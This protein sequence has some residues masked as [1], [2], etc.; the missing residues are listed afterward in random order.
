M[1]RL[2]APQLARRTRDFSDFRA[3]QRFLR[4]QQRYAIGTIDGVSGPSVV[5]GHEPAPAFDAGSIEG[6]VG[7]WRADANI[8]FHD[9]MWRSTSSL[10]QATVSGAAAG[11]VGV[12]AEVTRAGARGV[13]EFRYSAD[14]RETWL[15][16]GVTT[17]AS[18]PLIGPLAGLSID[19]PD[20]EYVLGNYAR[21]ITAWDR[22]DSIENKFTVTATAPTQDNVGGPTYLA[23]AQGEHGGVY[24]G[25]ENTQ[26]ARLAN[27]SSLSTRT[28]FCVAR[29]DAATFSNSERLLVN[30]S[31]STTLAWSGD[32]STG[33]FLAAGTGVLAGSRWTD[34]VETLDAGL[35]STRL[36]GLALDDNI[37][38]GWMLGNNSGTPRRPWGGP[39]FEL[40]IYNRVLTPAEWNYIHAGLGARYEIGVTLL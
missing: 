28:V 24:F 10:P 26:W 21:F 27:G 38:L 31:G 9:T 25:G 36:Y 32:G 4:E 17:S 35:G 7:W 20:E 6:L 34:G 37:S 18:V 23:A 30:A 3:A 13:A 29:R 16:E 19:F 39:V 1:A 11:L 8:V 5:L 33:N 12:W 15:E 40:I 14:N 22:V 2:T